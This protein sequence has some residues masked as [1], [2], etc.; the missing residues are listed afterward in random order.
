[1]TPSELQALVYDHYH[2]HGRHELPWRQTRDPYAILVSEVMLQQTQA[3][4]IAPRFTRWIERFPTWHSLAKAPLQEVLQEWQGLGYNRRALNLQKLAQTVAKTGLPSDRAGLEALPSIGPYTAGAVRAFAFNEPEVFIE[5]NIRRVFLHHLHPGEEG[6][7]DVQLMPEIA[8]ALDR[9]NPRD[10]YYALMDYGAWLKDQVPN[11]NRRSKHHSVQS[12]FE[13]SRRQVRGL[14]LKLVSEHGRV[15]V[16]DL[17]D[18][19]GVE[20]AVSVLEELE[21]E[22]FVIREE[23]Y[24]RAAPSA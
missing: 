16:R 12:R 1:M 7:S 19:Q 9:G 5:T 11:P 24:W 17:Q 23:T 22:G 3:S 13:G 14:A 21:K 15:R 10:W 20:V 8:E 2:K 4:R 18:L 6:V